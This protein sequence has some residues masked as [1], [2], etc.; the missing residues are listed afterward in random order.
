M[1]GYRCVSVGLGMSAKTPD[2]LNQQLISAIWKEGMV[3]AQGVQNAFQATPRHLFLPDVPL[4]KVYTD[5]AIPLKY[6]HSGILVSSCSQPTMIAIMLD[7]MRL[8]VGDNVLEIGTASGYNAAIMK[9]VVGDNGTVTTIEIDKEL[10]LQA[11]KNLNR[12]K[13]NDVRVVNADGAFGYLPRAAYD[14]I[15]ATVGVWDIP[16]VWIRQLK[17]NGALTVPLWLDGI[18]VSAKFTRQADG[19]LLSSD[20]RACAFVYMRGEESTPEFRRQVG[21]SSLYIVSDATPHIDTVRLHTLLGDNHEIAN[22]EPRL[23]PRDYW[24]GLQIYLMMNVPPRADFVLYSVSEEMKAYG[25]EGNGMGLIMPSSAVFAPYQEAGVTYSFGGSEAFVLLQAVF[26]AWNAKDRPMMRLLRVRLIPK[27]G[28]V[29]TIETGK[30]YERRHHYVQ[31]WL[32]S[33]TT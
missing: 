24:N 28:E 27:N 23:K 26:D 32:E 20:N 29:P 16:P 6:D 12:A 5:V 15:I 17:D 8:K 19:T 11:E 21:S 7:Q 4:E 3:R 31:V 10:A 30:L 25:L 9:H 33:E 13:V 2:Q 22:I 14:H 18:Q 1:L